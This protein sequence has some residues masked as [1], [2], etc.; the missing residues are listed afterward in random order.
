MVRTAIVVGEVSMR[1]CH[2]RNYQTNITIYTYACMYPYTEK[3]LLDTTESNDKAVKS[4]TPSDNTLLTLASH[5][6]THDQILL[7]LKPSL[8]LQM[9]DLGTAL[10]FPNRQSIPRQFSDHMD[11]YEG[12]N[13]DA[14]RGGARYYPILY[15]SEF[16]ITYDSL[17][18]VNGGLKE[19]KIDVTYEPVPVSNMERMY[20]Y[21]VACIVSNR[22]RLFYVRCGNGNSRPEWKTPKENKKPSPEK[23]TVPTT[24][25]LPCSLRLIPTCLQ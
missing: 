12:N 3:S 7:Y 22:M 17:K 8:T 6:K 20:C 13:V 18:E 9:V 14:F 5:N 11:W 16:W 25:Y 19:S 21:S 1:V 2:T 10:E 4:S 24:L 23:K 15:V